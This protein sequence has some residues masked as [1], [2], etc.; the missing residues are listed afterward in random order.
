[1]EI[2]VTENF[3]EQKM[4]DMSGGCSIY[5]PEANLSPKKTHKHYIARKPWAF[6]SEKYKI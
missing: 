1:M 3:Q 5:S 2:I 6:R 4:N